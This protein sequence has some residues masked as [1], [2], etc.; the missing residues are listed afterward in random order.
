MSVCQLA[1]AGAGGR[2][3]GAF[4]RAETEWERRREGKEE[5]ERGRKRN[6]RDSNARVRHGGGGSIG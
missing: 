1:G 2:E 3:G 5:S 4:V 6:S